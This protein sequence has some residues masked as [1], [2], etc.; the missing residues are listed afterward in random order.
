M[1]IRVYW[2]IDLTWLKVQQWQWF[3]G[4]SAL[5][6]FKDMIATPDQIL[7]FWRAAGP[8]KWFEADEVFDGEIR[9]RFVPT[10]E[11]AARGAL[12]HWQETTQA[13]L[14][15]LILLDQFPRNLF[16]GEARAYATDAQARAIAER[17]LRRGIDRE[18][19]T[20]E[21]Q[22]F[23]LPFMHSEN[24]ADQERCIALYCDGADAEGLR[25]AEIHADII[26]RFGR[27]PHRNRA[28]GRTTTPDE[29]AFLEGGGFGG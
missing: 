27:F 15:L 3:N 8:D 29:Q 6:P 25:H 23:Y 10:Y 4:C 24:V 7:A 22:F 17:A 11:A 21:R 16:R 14:A 20:E 1:D 28:L 9:A 2:S 12:D 5:R 26:R 18:F 13:T 19:P